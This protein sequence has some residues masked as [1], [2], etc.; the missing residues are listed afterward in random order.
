MNEHR[1]GLRMQQA[2]R[3][4]DA[5]AVIKLTRLALREADRRYRDHSLGWKPKVSLVA[6]TAIFMAVFWFF[7]ERWA[8]TVL[9]GA[10]LGYLLVVWPLRI[11]KAWNASRNSESAKFD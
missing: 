7:E 10:V 6:L 9:A 4:R 11:R 8:W 5:K 3:E 1:F 2:L